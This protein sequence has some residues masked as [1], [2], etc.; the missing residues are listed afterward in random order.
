MYDNINVG[1]NVTVVGKLKGKRR[2]LCSVAIC[3]VLVKDNRSKHSVIE[4]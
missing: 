2:E 4:M 3:T 1:I